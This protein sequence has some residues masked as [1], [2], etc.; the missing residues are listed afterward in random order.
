MASENDD[1][2]KSLKYKDYIVFLSHVHGILKLVSP[3]KN[4]IFQMD[5]LTSDAGGGVGNILVFIKYSC[6]GT[7]YF[8]GSQGRINLSSSQNEIT[9]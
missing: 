6:E 4:D 3:K 1:F 8:L 9:L 5:Y 7:S 2:L